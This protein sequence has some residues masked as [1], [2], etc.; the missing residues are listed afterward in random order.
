MTERMWLGRFLVYLLTPPVRALMR[1]KIIGKENIPP[2]GEKIV[3]CCNHISNWDPVLLEVA[4][5]MRHIYFMAKAELFK[6]RLF[7]WLLGKQIGAFA[8]HRGTGDTAALDTAKQLVE[9]GKIMGIFPEGT[10]SKDGKLMRAK[11]GTALIVS[12]TGAMVLPVAIVTRGQHVRPLRR[13]LVVYG[14]PVTPAELH[15]DGEKPD[16]RYASRRLMEIIGGLIEQHRAEVE[17]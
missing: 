4:Q 2:K 13:T 17:R 8:V 15:L 16:I 14:K 5:P 1:V 3:L 6:N 11:S 9:D 12:Q 10:R 7:A